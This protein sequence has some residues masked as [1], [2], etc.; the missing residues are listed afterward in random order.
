[1]AQTSRLSEEISVYEVGPVV[2]EHLR[3]D[4]VSASQSLRSVR[5]ATRLTPTLYQYGALGV[6]L[7]LIGVLS[8]FKP[9]NL[10]D[11]APL[12]LL[13]IRAL[14]YIKQ[15]L[16]ASQAGNEVYPYLDAIRS[17]LEN[18][19]ANTAKP[20]TRILSSFDSLTLEGVGFEY[21]P[22]VLWS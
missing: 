22:G 9:G 19:R 13:M 6:V 11:L 3:T 10:A 20:G 21:I 17:E 7:M 4:V 12:I 5:T 8:V 1:M 14:A 16:Q 15:L 18:L 2:V